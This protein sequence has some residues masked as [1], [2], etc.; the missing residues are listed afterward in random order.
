[1]AIFSEFLPGGSIADLLKNFNS[2]AEPVVKVYMR[3][4]L[5]GLL[6]IHDAGIVHGDI[7]CA[8]I[9]VDDLGNTKLTD[10]SFIKHIFSK[11]F[12]PDKAL[13]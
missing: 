9:L 10:F 12:T 11:E 2:F 3:G 6:S 7:K 1:M 8:N 13:I 5:K 4:M